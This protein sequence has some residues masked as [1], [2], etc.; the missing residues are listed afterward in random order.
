MKRPSILSL[1]AAEDKVS[2]GERQITN[3]R[4]FILSLK[5][6]GC[7]PASEVAQL[8][9]MEEAQRGH[10]AERDGLRVQLKVLT[11]IEAA[12]AQISLSSLATA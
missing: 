6:A 5:C 11:A 8:R 9:E 7:D 12:R 1:Q 2:S 3:R 4:D 10:I